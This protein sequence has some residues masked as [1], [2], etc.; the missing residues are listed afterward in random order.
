MPGAFQ[1][2]LRGEGRSW[3]AYAASLAGVAAALFLSLHIAPLGEG[4][5]FLLLVAAVTAG[6]SLAGLGPGVLAGVSAALG[7]SYVILPRL[8]SSSGSVPFLV[9]IIVASLIIALSASAR[10]VALLA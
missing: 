4:A 8:S 7:Y 1:G 2:G 9:F 6:A 10:R 5:S 3:R